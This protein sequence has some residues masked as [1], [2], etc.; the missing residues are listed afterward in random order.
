MS[1]PARGVQ[2]AARRPA[3]GRASRVREA[4]RG[5]LTAGIADGVFP[6]AVAA[7][8]LGRERLVLDALGHAQVT[9]R[10]VGMRGDTIFDLASLTKPVVTVTAILRLWEQGRIDLDAPVARYLPDFAQR[11]KATVT[12]RHLLAHTS[13]LPAWEMLYLPSPPNGDGTRAPACRS[14]GE[15]V[16]RICAVPA[17]APPGT[18]IEYSDLGFI[19]LGWLVERLGAP[20]DVYGREHIFGPLGMRRTRFL[21][22]RSWRRWCAA[23][24][25]GNAYERGK[26]AEQG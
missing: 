22:P 7:V 23:T 18:R 15:A 25:I 3:R 10:R 2:M 14:I 1:A 5:L 4:V 17:A 20:L 26:A 19:L 6:G 8:M 9:P 13:G 12:I 16:A 11:G 24:E 21:P